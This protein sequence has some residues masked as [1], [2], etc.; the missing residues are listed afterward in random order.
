MEPELKQIKDPYAYSDPTSLLKDLQAEFRALTLEQQLWLQQ[1]PSIHPDDDETFAMRRQKMKRLQMDI[2]QCQD[3]VLQ[4]DSMP[5]YRVITL[6]KE[7]SPLK[8]HHMISRSRPVGAPRV[9]THIVPVLQATPVIEEPNLLSIPPI[10]PVTSQSASRS[11]VPIVT[12]RQVLRVK[13]VSRYGTQ[14]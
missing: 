9:L 6:V 4:Q 11:P 10:P 13:K 8:R 5:L 1:N 3:L 2:L 7:S 12:P 14:V